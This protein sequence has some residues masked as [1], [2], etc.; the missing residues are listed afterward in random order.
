MSIS[1]TR[2]I[3][4]GLLASLAALSAAIAPASAQQQTPNI[5]VIMADDIGYWNISAYTAGVHVGAWRIC[6][7]GVVL[8]A[9]VPAIAWLEQSALLLVLAAVV[10]I[11]VTA[12]LRLRV[13]KA[14][15]SGTDRAAP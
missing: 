9:G 11:A 13:G 15:K 3:W 6:L 10:L 4:L 1:V 2:T 12:P 14:S 8:G 5:L 7:V